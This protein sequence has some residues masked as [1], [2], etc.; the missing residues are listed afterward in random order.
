MKKEYILGVTIL[1][2]S[3][4][5]YAATFVNPIDYKDTEE[6][7]Q[8]VIE[9][10]EEDTKRTYCETVDMCSPTTLRMMEKQN[11]D[12]FKYLTEVDSKELLQKVINDYCNVGMCNYSTIRMMYD[13][14]NKASK[15][16]LTW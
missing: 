5:I 15:E 6:N 10:I 11:L 4:N 12:A 14:N 9:Y 16:K 3:K 13:S 2:C 7:R 1:L 8:K